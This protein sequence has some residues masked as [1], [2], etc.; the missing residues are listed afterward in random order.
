MRDQP[1]LRLPGNHV[2]RARKTNRGFPFDAV[3][4]L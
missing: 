1:T 4:N 3:K 2:K